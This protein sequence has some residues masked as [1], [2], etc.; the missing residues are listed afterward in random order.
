MANKLT[1]TEKRQITKSLAGR[2]C[3]F[4]EKQ[5]DCR[6]SAVEINDKVDKCDISVVC[7]GQHLWLLLLCESKK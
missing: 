1:N 6:V 3:A 5:G 4:L 7:Q 2:L